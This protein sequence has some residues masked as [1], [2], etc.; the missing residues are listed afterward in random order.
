MFIWHFSTRLSF[1]YWFTSVLPIRKFNFC[2][3]H[4]M[5]ICSP[6]FHL[7]FTFP[8]DMVGQNE[9]ETNYVVK[10][11]SPSFMTFGICIRLIMFFSHQ[12]FINI[13][14][15]FY[16]DFN[17]LCTWLVSFI[18]PLVRTHYLLC[19]WRLTIALLVFLAPSPPW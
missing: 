1:C 4:W 15:I 12:N 14:H 3:L 10:C 17:I 9:G 7:V 6:C 5:L 16:W 2:L 19:N 18:D 8:Y 11:T 13:S